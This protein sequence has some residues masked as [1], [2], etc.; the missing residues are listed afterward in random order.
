MTYNLTGM[1]SNVTSL[2]TFIQGVNTTLMGGWFGTIFLMGM[3]GVLFGSFMFT[4][5]GDVAKSMSGSLFLC[6]VGAIFLRA[7]DLVPNLAIYVTLIGLAVSLALTWK[8]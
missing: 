4:T 7:L 2:S 3:F 8:E 5:S 6:F 1:A